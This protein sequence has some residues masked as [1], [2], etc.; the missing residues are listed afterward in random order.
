MK[1]VARVSYQISQTQRK[2]KFFIW[3]ITKITN[4]H[5]YGY[6]GREVVSG[7]AQ[8]RT[9]RQVCLAHLM[10][11]C[12]PRQRKSL[13]AQA[14]YCTPL[15]LNFLLVVLCTISPK[16]GISLHT[17]QIGNIVPF[18]SYNYYFLRRQQHDINDDTDNQNSNDNDGINNNN[19]NS[20]TNTN[21]SK[22]DYNTR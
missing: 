6:I 10:Y 20:N 5:I 22:D 18:I 7:V 4:K 14:P 1:C 8:S 2:F 12:N 19:Q 13:F 17:Q 16:K 9:P 21:T 15:N 3:L 11:K